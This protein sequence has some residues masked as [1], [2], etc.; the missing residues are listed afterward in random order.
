MRLIPAVAGG[1]QRR[2]D[3]R[4]MVA[5]IVDDRDAALLPAL[6]KSPVHAGKFR[7]SLANQVGR[8]SNSSA[9]AMAAV[10]FSTL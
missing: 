9:M 2:A 3:L 7:Q 4:G 1:G 8:I 5:V 6:L 10:A